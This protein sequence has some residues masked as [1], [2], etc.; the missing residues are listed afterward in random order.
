MSRRKAILVG[1]DGG[2][3]ELLRILF[4]RGLLPTLQE[5]E[6]EGIHADLMSTVPSF[7]CPAWTSFATGTNPGKHGI[8]EFVRYDE[9]Y[10][11]RLVSSRDIACDTFYDIMSDAGFRTILINLPM[12]YPPKNVNGI[13]LAD[14]LAPKVYAYPPSASRYIENYRNMYDTT[15]RGLEYI[16]DVL[17]LEE[18]RF[19]TAREIFITEDWDLFLL[20]FSGT[21]WLSH[22]H[23]LDMKAGTPEGKL[24]A[25]VFVMVDSALRWFMKYLDTD[26]IL[27]VFSDHGFRSYEGL[28]RINTWLEQRELL[29]R[30]DKDEDDSKLKS[31]HEWRGFSSHRRKLSLPKFILSLASQNL[32]VRRAG[33]KLISTLWNSIPMSKDF[34]PDVDN[35]LAFVPSIF[36]GGIFIN[37]SKLEQKQY[38]DLVDSIIKE[39][40]NIKDEKGN[41][42][43][44]KVDRKEHFFEGNCTKFAPDVLYLEGN[45]WRVDISLSFDR[46]SLLIRESTAGHCRNGILLARG[47][48]IARRTGHFVWNILD[49]APTLLY[50][51]GLPIPTEMDGRPLIEM[52]SEDAAAERPRYESFESGEKRKVRERIRKLKGNELMRR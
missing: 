5:L 26:T 37:K 34:R 43:L 7:T 35:S 9:N 10:S 29:E 47:D 1:I 16:H 18:E 39:M 36:T 12:S 14:F 22:S 42:V 30:T 32:F 13:I 41:I 38:E 52:F 8:F 20:V 3:W 24:A 4:N 45:D 31:F 23:Y 44:D 48:P 27:L 17:E 6:R 21:D 15:K 51:F 11:T 50:Y 19:K 46:E 2:G 28:F 40:R 49:I 25:K 33:K